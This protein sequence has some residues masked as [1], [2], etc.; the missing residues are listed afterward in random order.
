LGTSQSKNSGKKLNQKV[1]EIGQ[2]YPETTIEVWAMD[3]H[4]SAMFF[5]FFGWLTENIN[6]FASYSN[7]C[8]YN[9]TYY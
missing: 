2:K 6:V 9:T 4:P 1:Q 5:R 7:V 8:L 3:E